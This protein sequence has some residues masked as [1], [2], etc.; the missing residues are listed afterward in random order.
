MNLDGTEQTNAGD[1]SRRNRERVELLTEASQVGIWFCDLPF[2][3]LMW[4]DR[5]KEHFWL[6]PETR[7]TINLFY[8]RLHPD[9]REPTRLAIERS[10]HEKT[11][12][13]IDYR[14]VAPDGRQKWIRALGHA[15]YDAQNNPIRFDGVT[16]DISEGKFA[17]A[18]NRFLVALDDVLR[19][20]SD[21]HT[22][23]IKAAQALGEYLDADR[24]A[25]ADVEADQNSMHLTGNY[26]RGPEIKSIVGDLKFSDFGAEVL[27][28]MREDKPFVVHNIDSHQPPVGDV[29][30]YRATQIQSVI[31]VPLHKSG[32][33][34]A[35]MAV[36]MSSPRHWQPAEVELVR[37]V[38]ARCWESI[39]R[40]RLERGLH[41]SEQRYRS[42]FDSI[43]EGFC[44]IEM[45]FDSNNKPID[46]RFMEVNPAFEKQAGMVGA[47][48]KRMLEFVSDIEPHWLEKYGRVALTGRPIRFAAEYKSLNRWF[49]VYAFPVGEPQE[50]KVA[51]IF[52]NITAKRSAEEA[53]RDET[54]ILE[55]LNSTGAAI[56]A[57]L[58]LQTLVQI[59]T[60]AGRKLC[61]AKFG[62]FFY[63]AI[64]AQGEMYMLYSLSGAPRE[65]FDKF[66][67]PRNTPVFNATFS[68]ERVVR[69]DDIT[70]D[71]LYGKW[72][73]HHGM[74]AGHLPVRSYLAVPVISRNGEVIGGLFFGHPEPGVFTERSERLLVGIAAQT[75]IAID[76]ARLYE[77]AQREIAERIRVAE[78]L[79][80]TKEELR[81]HAENLEQQVADRTASLREAL[82][83]LEEF[84]YSVSHDLRAPL[85]AISGYSRVFTEEFG[86]ALPSEAHLYLDKI[87]RN[88][89]RMDRLINDVLTL[90]RVARADLQLKPFALQQFIEDLVEQHPNMQSPNADL[91]IHTPHTVMGDEARL[92]QALSNLLTNAVKFVPP[93]QKP[94]VRLHSESLGDC[95]RI[96]VDDFGIGIPADKQ[97]KL[98]CIFQRLTAND[99]Y[100]GTGIGL[101]IVRKAVEVMGGT[102]GMESNQ[103][104]GSRFW[105]DLKKG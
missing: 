22:I 35:A 10:I 58:D 49:D 98:F 82:E 45:L 13:T 73:P 92:S 52:T 27:Q 62:A 19:P 17:E 68:G 16:I 74:P 83:Q 78:E 2:D 56:A 6:P 11:R 5:V 48:G 8:E 81:H 69:S 43:D 4:D 25:Y 31:C 51:V 50:K 47:A 57:E 3:E 97:K 28:L 46:Y 38:A 79:Q 64:N 18:R 102:V 12:Y 84:S 60:D 29:A 1:L 33:L 20:L 21:P 93:N 41:Q 24:C 32:R 96:W 100:E 40:A 105:I 90:S 42:L 66:G 63:N 104:S 39:E 59:V 91:Q 77:G 89:E 70:K 36:H 37:A 15:H 30:S 95:V 86:E 9:D 44:V 101:A 87:A 65:A 14:T 94:V 75:A 26:V 80:K 71:P 54:R 103:P 99:R 76:N 34:V 53:L 61:G 67:M 7:V 72:G 55:I 85:R 88:A 23:T